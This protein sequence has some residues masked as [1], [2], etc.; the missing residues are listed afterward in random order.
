MPR[1]TSVLRRRSGAAGLGLCLAGIMLTCHEVHG[2]FAVTNGLTHVHHSK[3]VQQGQLNLVNQTDDSLHLLLHTDSLYG[4]WE[5]LVIP[6][7]VWLAPHAE[8]SLA[9]EWPDADST[10]VGT[11]VDV[12]PSQSWSGRAVQGLEIRH[13]LRYRVAIYR[14]PIRLANHPEQ[15]MTQDGDTLCVANGT[16]GMLIA[17]IHWRNRHGASE[18]QEDMKLLLPGQQIQFPIPHPTPFAA[19]LIDHLERAAALRLQ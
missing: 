9:Y 5:Q 15:Q 10:L 8:I 17:A 7:E 16:D 14:G 19:W 1:R 11:L 6:S 13:A 4:S 12:E 3:W 18:S 2:Q